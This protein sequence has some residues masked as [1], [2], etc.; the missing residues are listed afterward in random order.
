MMSP[1][2]F[3]CGVELAPG[4]LDM[5]SRIRL[6]LVAKTTGLEALAHT[7]TAVPAEAGEVRWLWEQLP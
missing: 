2:P 3:T 7:R 6:H 1:E 4:W 5:R